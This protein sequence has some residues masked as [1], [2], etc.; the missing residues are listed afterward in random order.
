MAEEHG[1]IVTPIAER[2]EQLAGF[3]K[4]LE[5][6]DSSSGQLEGFTGGPSQAQEVWQELQP[7]VAR[8]GRLEELMG[9][10]SQP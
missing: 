1:Q 6:V 7:S 3:T 10:W 8:V 4:L 2:E 5:V 9:W